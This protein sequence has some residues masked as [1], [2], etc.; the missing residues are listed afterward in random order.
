MGA[1]FTF[2]Q[3][4]RAKLGLPDDLNIIPKDIQHL[5]DQLHVRFPNHELLKSRWDSET[6]LVS[7]MD[8]NYGKQSYWADGRS[9]SR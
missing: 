6:A 5:R 3:E 8:S 9:F 4:G 2:L 1:V 7:V